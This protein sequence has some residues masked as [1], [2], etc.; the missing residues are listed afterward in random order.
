MT[1]YRRQR[2][3]TL[4]LLGTPANL[5]MCA[6]WTFEAKDGSWQWSVVEHTPCELGVVDVSM[7]TLTTVS[8]QEV[9]STDN[10]H[11]CHAVHTVAAA[12]PAT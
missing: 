11:A 5:I 1:F 3:E 4:A 10:A 8:V 12:C 6:V 2:K 9:T 7:D